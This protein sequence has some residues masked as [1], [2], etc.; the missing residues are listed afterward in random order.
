MRHDSTWLESGDAGSRGDLSEGLRNLDNSDAADQ[1]VFWRS[2]IDKSIGEVE[3]IGGLPEDTVFNDILTRY[4]D[5]SNRAMHVVFDAAFRD[6]EEELKEYQEGTG[7]KLLS[8]AGLLDAMTEHYDLY[9]NE[10]HPGFKK[11]CEV[12]GMPCSRSSFTYAVRR[13]RIAIL[14][15]THGLVPELSHKNVGSENLLDRK[16]VGK[17]YHFDYDDDNLYDFE[18]SEV[19]G[20]V[21]HHGSRF[22]IPK[23]PKQIPIADLAKYLF[24]SKMRRL[25][26]VH[27]THLQF[28]AKELVL[29]IS[30]VWRVSGFRQALMCNLAHAQPQIEIT[31]LRSADDNVQPRM[32]RQQSSTMGRALSVTESRSIADQPSDG[33]QPQES[34]LS[35][36]MWSSLVMPGIFLDRTSQESLELYRQWC[37]KRRDPTLKKD[38]NPYPPPIHIAAVQSTICMLWSDVKENALVSVVSEPTYIGKWNTDAP[39]QSQKSFATRLLDIMTCGCGD[40]D[41]SGSKDDPKGQY[42]KLKSCDPADLEAN[43]TQYQMSDELREELAKGLEGSSNDVA[44]ELAID[45]EQSCCSFDSCFQKVLLALESQNSTLRLS[46]HLLLLTRITLN[47][48]AAFLDVLDVYEAAVARIGYLLHQSS[49]RDKDD[50]IANIELVLYHLGHLQRVVQ[51]FADYVV[52]ELSKIVPNMQV[53]FPLEFHQVQDIRHNI[54]IFGPK[55]DSLKHQCTALS[56]EYDRIASDKMN[57]ILN[58]LTFITFVIT[59]MQILTGLYGMNFKIIPELEWRYGYHYFWTLSGCLTILFALILVCLKRQSD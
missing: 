58:L 36:W 17:V 22:N 57:D 34:N 38:V 44:G 4:F 20:P 30:Q 52:P 32:S 40:R 46:S 29:A 28:P 2:C 59:P 48:T 9:D 37:A 12:V 43:T 21:H 5:A 19:R 55:I 39:Y 16:D 42:S 54:Q 18:A 15:Y 49:T 56:Q 10:D 26:R 31:T 11:V 50:L 7:E 25:G 33:E 35:R 51:P 45:E 27:W 1:A 23:L 14:L 8:K 24:T 13:L 47:K 3:R 53:D 41:S 6:Q